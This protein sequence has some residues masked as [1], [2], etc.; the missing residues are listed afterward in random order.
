MP[1]INMIAARRSETKRLESKTRVVLLVLVAEVL[2]TVFMLSFMAARAYTANRQISRLDKELE[3]IQPTVDKI[4]EY[5]TQI[6]ELK[7]RLDLLKESRIKTLFWYDVMQDLSKSMAVDTWLNSITTMETQSSEKKNTV[8][9]IRGV[10]VS[11]RNVGETMLRL[12]QWPEFQHVDLNYTQEGTALSRET[13][14][15][16]IALSL[17]SFDSQKGGTK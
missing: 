10:S 6:A 1:S 9:N 2:L 8:V 5:E 13:L 12:N 11:Q 3:V 15:F 17:S 14:D 7:P 4:N 16:E